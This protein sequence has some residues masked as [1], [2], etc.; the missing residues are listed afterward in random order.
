[1]TR[2][3]ALLVPLAALGVFG[4]AGR[5]RASRIDTSRL[6]RDLARLDR[7]RAAADAAFDE[8]GVRDRPIPA[9]WG[10]AEEPLLER[11]A[12]VV[13][14]EEDVVAIAGA[15]GPFVYGGRRFVYE[16]GRDPATWT[17]TQMLLTSPL[18]AVARF[19]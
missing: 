8:A 18:G 1:M 16:P 9:E 2:R 10:D 4:F 6:A 17:S 19:A 12:A 15:E 14:A 7:A 3:T 5:A 11:L 13:E